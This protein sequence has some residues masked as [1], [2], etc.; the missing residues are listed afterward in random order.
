MIEDQSR[1]VP[2]A[3][4]LWRLLLEEIALLARRVGRLKVLVAMGAAFASFLFVEVALSTAT[5][6]PALS[7][8]WRWLVAMA[9]TCLTLFSWAIIHAVRSTRAE[10]SKE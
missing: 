1:P 4:P 5:P 8:W 6:G 7:V 2:C 9:L 3:L 10:S